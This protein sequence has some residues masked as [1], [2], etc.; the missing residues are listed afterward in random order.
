LPLGTKPIGCKWIFKIKLKLGGSLDKFK[1][2]LVAK[3]DTQKIDFDYFDTF[4]LVTRIA[5]IRV[6]FVLGSI[7]KL[8]IY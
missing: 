6:L 8:L 7:H 5:S 4:A 3:G 2:R 1:G